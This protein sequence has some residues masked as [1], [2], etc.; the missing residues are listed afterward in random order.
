MKSI[1]FTEFVGNRLKSVVPV[2]LMRLE[3]IS[4]YHIYTVYDNMG[5]KMITVCMNS[6]YCFIL[7]VKCFL[8]KSHSDIIHNLRCTFARF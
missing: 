6:Y 7:S 3:L 4:R 8:C 2:S 1:F 5:M